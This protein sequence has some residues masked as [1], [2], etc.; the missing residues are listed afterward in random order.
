[1]LQLKQAWQLTQRVFALELKCVCVCMCRMGLRRREDL[2]IYIYIYI[3]IQFILYIYKYIYIY[4]YIQ[5]HIYLY[6]YIYK[7]YIYFS[8]LTIY[9]WPKYSNSNNVLIK[10]D[11]INLFSYEIFH[12]KCYNQLTLI[13]IF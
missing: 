4:T 2:H 13:K 11:R 8:N 10:I 5:I 7:L 1:M 3:N 12:M 6:I 9:L